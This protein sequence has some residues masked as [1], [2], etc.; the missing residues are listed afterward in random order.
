MN[1][2]ACVAFLQWVLPRLDLRWQGFRKVRRQVCRHIGRRIT[3]LELSSAE[4]YRQYL[5]NHPEEWQQLDCLC[6][7]TISRFYR[8]RIVFDYLITDVLPE[9]IHTTRLRDGGQMRVLSIGSA[10]GEEPYT[11]SLIWHYTVR[12]VYPDLE[13]AVLATDFAPV[14]LERGR[15]ACYPASSLYE[16]PPQWRSD[17]FYRQGDQFCLKKALKREVRFQHFDIRKQTLEESFHLVLCRN[18]AFTYF[19][20]S[21][22]QVVLKKILSIMENNGVLVT[23]THEHIDWKSAGLVPWAEHMPLYRKK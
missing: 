20:S 21:L 17:A 11:I 4:H 6:R 18:L 23:G 22:Q 3:E 14:M 13:L 15:Q 10:S 19:S 12:P 5:E 1:D 16:L 9:L 2:Q 8:N 7:V